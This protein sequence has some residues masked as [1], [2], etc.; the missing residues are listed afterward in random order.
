LLQSAHGFRFCEGSKFAIA[1]RLGRSPLTHCWR[2]RAAC[3]TRILVCASAYG[4]TIM[5]TMV[6]CLF[7]GK[8]Y[9]YD[10]ETF[11]IDGQLL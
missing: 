5:V 9:S 6:T 10:V 3:D 1:H 2:Y 11:G 7:T 8:H 4:T